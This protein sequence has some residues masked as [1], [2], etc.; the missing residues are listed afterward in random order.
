MYQRYI[1]SLN[2]RNRHFAVTLRIEM[3]EFRLQ[4]CDR[5]PLIEAE[6]KSG[7]LRADLQT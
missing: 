2:R 4:V 1:V 6:E 7:K 5:C 3:V